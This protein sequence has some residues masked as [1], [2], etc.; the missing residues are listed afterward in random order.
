MPDKTENQEKNEGRITFLFGFEEQKKFNLPS[1]INRPR[2]NRS[3]SL[4]DSG[5]QFS[6]PLEFRGKNSQLV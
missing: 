2:S 4:P 1:L 5:M 6:I 3:L